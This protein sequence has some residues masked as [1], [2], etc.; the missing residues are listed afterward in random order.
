MKTLIAMLVGIAMMQFAAFAADMPK[1][2]DN[3]PDFSVAA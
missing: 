3:A 2:G 1:V